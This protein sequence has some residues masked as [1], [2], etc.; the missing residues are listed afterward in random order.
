M[1]Q[2]TVPTRSEIAREHTWNAESVF[3]TPDDWER[4]FADVAALLPAL[5]RFRGHLGDNPATL[6]DWLATADTLGARLGKLQVYGG[7]AYS[8]DATNQ[9]A[10]SRYDRVRGLTS[11]ALAAMAFAEPEL[12]AIG[13]PTLREWMHNDKQ[14]TTYE[15]YVDQLERRSAHV[16]SAEVEELLGMVS[17]PFA[18]ASATH[19]ILVNADLHFAPARGADSAEL[20]VTHGTIGALLTHTDRAVRRSAW[21]NYADAHLSMK[22][23]MA[24]CL[25]AGVKQ[26]VFAARVRRYPSAIEASLGANNIPP[27]VFHNLIA[28]FRS[29]LPTW[30]RY[31]RIR[32]QALGY[33]KLY[34]YDVKAPLSAEPPQV[35]FERAVEWITAGMRP[36]GDEYVDI[37][38]R[39]ATEQR[40]VDIYPNQG[41][42]MGAFSSGTQGT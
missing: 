39:G 10:K 38:R 19:G 30:H 42:R 17:D 25:T 9:E 29:N 1:S 32:R 41:K 34:E 16:R 37:L 24:S 35:P 11:Q 15:H 21:E 8:V 3:A 26:Q 22:N 6:A 20:D 13:F 23:T 28:T 18:T 27:A 12:L 31:W 14:L 5:D 4:E 36:L 2:T 7:M 33:D 40:W